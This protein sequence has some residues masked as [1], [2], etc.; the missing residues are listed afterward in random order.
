M[1]VAIALVW[2]AV[3]KHKAETVELKKQEMW[4]ELIAYFLSLYTE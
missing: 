4:E 1:A 3:H 2:P